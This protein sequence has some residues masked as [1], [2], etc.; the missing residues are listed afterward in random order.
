MDARE[1]ATLTGET[2]GD[3]MG[4]MDR[5]MGGAGEGL[6]GREGR[7]V[8]EGLKSSREICDVLSI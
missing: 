4:D 6:D 1:L 3:A 2:R 5:V 8:R 7:R